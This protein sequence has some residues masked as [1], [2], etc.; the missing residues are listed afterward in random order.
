MALRNG[1]VQRLMLGGVTDSI[2]GTDAPPGSLAAAINAVPDPSTNFLWTARPAAISLTTFAGFEAPGFISALLV[3]GNIA[4]GMVASERNSGHD[5]PFAFNLATGNFLTVSG[6]T[7]ANTPTSPSTGGQDWVPP[8]MAQIGRRVIVT[9]P[10]FSGGPIKFGWFDI[11]GFTD[12]TK[13]ATV[14]GTSSTL[15]VLS[16]DVI[17][18]GWQPGYVLSGTGIPAGTTIV[19][20]APDGLSLVMSNAATGG[21][22]SDVAIT[23]TGGTAAAPQ[24]A[25]GDT[26]INP[27]PSLPVAVAQFNGRAY[28]ACGVNGVVFSDSLLPCQVTNATQALNFG[29]GL[30]TTAL[31]ALPL[32]SPITGGIIQ[33]IIAFQGVQAM[34]QITGDET[35]SNLTVN[36]L[37]VATGTLSP[38]SI[39][40]TELG[41]IFMSPEGLRLINFSATVSP[42]LGD[43]GTGVTVPF[44]DALFPSRICVAASADTIRATTQNGGVTGQPSQEYWFDMTRKVWSGPHTSAC[45]QIELWGGTFLAVLRGVNGTLFQSDAVVTPSSSYTENGVPLTYAITTSLSPD[46]GDDSVQA[47]LESTIFG[48]FPSPPTIMVVDDYGTTLDTVQLAAPTTGTTWGNFTWGPPSEWSASPLNARQRAIPWHNWLIFKQAQITI[49]GASNPKLRFGNLEIRLSSL[50]YQLAELGPS[51]V[52]PFGSDLVFVGTSPITFV[53]TSPIVWKT[54]S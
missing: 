2:D 38:L 26:N 32:A 52:T 15:T 29:N 1:R 4:Y 5:E 30:A 27:L 8:I 33:A 35:T 19:S 9:H 47:V 46:T 34:Q 14:T 42:P 23:A 20:I 41:L 37:N 49:S 31:G 54:H 11:S 43:H 45:D 44:I 22:G 48:S 39:T 53:G 12:A 36:V 13:T 28:Y 6:I 10:G 17:T 7:A 51:G 21:G 3:I 16:A 40:P 18:A 25:A 24:W 50:G